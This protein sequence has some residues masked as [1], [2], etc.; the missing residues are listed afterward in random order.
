TIDPLDGRLQAA[1]R[2]LAGLPVNAKVADVGCGP[3]RFVHQLAAEF[4]GVRFV[5]VDP[6]RRWLMRMSNEIEPRLGS[7]LAIPAAEGEFDGV[8]AVES[9]EHALLPEHAVNEICRVVRRGGSVLVI[10]K[11]RARQALSRHEPWEQW[12][13]P[14]EVVRWLSLACDDV[15]LETVSHGRRPP[16][17]PLFLAWSGTVRHRPSEQRHQPNSAMIGW[18]SQTRCGRSC[19]S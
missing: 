19:R 5:G 4:P 15:R 12:F 3:G 11:N 2:W 10:D 9:L 13:E 8:L 16:A 18:P 6:S 17:R 14:Q 7:L 1:R